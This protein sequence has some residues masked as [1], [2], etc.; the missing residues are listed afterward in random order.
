LYN[1][2]ITKHELLLSAEW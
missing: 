2:S 1:T